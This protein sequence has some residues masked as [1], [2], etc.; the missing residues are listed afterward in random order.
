[1]RE[2]PVGAL[3]SVI[4]CTTCRGNLWDVEPEDGTLVCQL[5]GRVSELWRAPRARTV[6]RRAAWEEH[7]AELMEPELPRRPCRVC[8]HLTAY[9]VRCGTCEMEYRRAKHQ[10]YRDR[11]K[12]EMQVTA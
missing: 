7:K 9:S 10:R 12:D 11:Q 1:M 3:L 2:L 8:G 4:H 5:C 6:T